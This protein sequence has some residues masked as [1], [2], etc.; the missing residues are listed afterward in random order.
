M[1][2]FMPYIGYSGKAVAVLWSRAAT[3]ATAA[4]AAA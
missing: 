3:A 2:M 4:T 1:H